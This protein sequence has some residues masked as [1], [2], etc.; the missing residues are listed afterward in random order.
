MEEPAVDLTGVR[1]ICPAETIVYSSTRSTIDPAEKLR[2]EPLPCWF[3]RR[4]APWRSSAGSLPCS[5]PV[6]GLLGGQ[7]FTPAEP[8]R[9]EKKTPRQNFN[10][11]KKL[12]W[13]LFGFSGRGGRGASCLPPTTEW[14]CG[15]PGRF[16]QSRRPHD[17]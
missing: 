16:H 6:G 9:S 3:F 13:L 2:V 12:F 10:T 8:R 15:G 1:D 17:L 4:W 7:L 5:A 11:L 14:A